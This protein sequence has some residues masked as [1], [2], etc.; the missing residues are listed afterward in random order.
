MLKRIVTRVLLVCAGIAVAVVG[1]EAALQVA[2]PR[3]QGHPFSADEYRAAIHAASTASLSARPTRGR[4]GED[5]RSLPTVIHPYLGFIPEPRKD[6]EFV[7]GEVDQI[8]PHSDGELVVGVFGGSFAAGMCAYAAK[9]L[10]HVLSH[11]GK[12]ARVLCLAA[13]GFKQPQQLLTLAYL[14]AQG[15]RFDLVLNVDGFNEV[16]L[17]PSENKPQGVAPIYP[18]GWFWHVGNLEDPEALKLLGELALTDR[19]RQRW[20]AAVEDWGLYRSAL[21][22]LTW[23]S[24]DRLLEAQ[25]D[26]I[27]AEL[28]AHKV[29]QRANYAATGPSMTFADDE[30]YYAYLA[31]VW[32]D[33]SLQMQRLCDANGIAYAHFLQ[34]NQ[35]V[36]GSKP[37][38][39]DEM[40]LI[41][42][43]TPYKRP[44]VLGYPH[45]RRAGEELAAAGVNFHDLTMIFKDEPTKLYSDGC[46]HLNADGYNRVARTIG[47][48]VDGTAHASR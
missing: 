18:R 9:E 15:A 27:L 40:T 45:L 30:A 22:S 16:A 39:P 7:I 26:R 29:E 23:K 12:E 25:H 5:P 41:T 14:L 3:L 4:A 21:L 35:Y 38:L 42:H 13:G 47:E 46:C 31:R 44:V 48:T 24:R 19:A 1:A 17:P 28:R 36:E 10:H 32:K 11:Q 20:A 33:S 34:P 43:P 2:Y 6:G 8:P 37:M